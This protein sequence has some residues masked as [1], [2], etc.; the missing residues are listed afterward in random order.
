MC[1]LRERDRQSERERQREREDC[2]IQTARCWVY[3]P[4]VVVCVQEAP[5]SSRWAPS[6][7]EDPTRCTLL[8]LAWRGERSTSL[9][10]LHCT[11]TQT[12]RHTDRQ[13]NK[14]TNT[15]TRPEEGGGVNQLC[16]SSLHRHTDR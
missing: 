13:M 8:A 16:E 5:S 15:R 3:H 6:L 10:S 7:V 11:H 4:C 12:D 1:V 2:S 9:V 14:H